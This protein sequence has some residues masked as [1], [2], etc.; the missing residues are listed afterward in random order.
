MSKGRWPFPGDSPTAA[1][2]KVALAYR[3][4]LAKHDQA[5]VDEM[6]RRFQQWGQGWVNPEHR[7]YDP[8]DMITAEEAGALIGVVAGTI[9][10][11]RL[12]N[13][14]KGEF[15]G[16]RFLYRV[17]DVY[18]LSN[19]VR[20]RKDSPTVRVNANGTTVSSGQSEPTPL[21]PRVRAEA[22]ALF[23]REAG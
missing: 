23:R 5:A 17:S 15:D 19:S 2:R 16:K 20:R 7:D 1:A 11:L 8:D 4:A 13:R 6:D 21:L 22:E 14:I 9:G 3:E 18:Q 12:R 10:H